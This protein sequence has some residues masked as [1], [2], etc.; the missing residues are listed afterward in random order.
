LREWAFR[1][2][3][4]TSADRGRVLQGW[5]EHYNRARPHTSLN[6]SRL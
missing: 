5:L 6:G 2:P 3:Y 1:Q 4:R